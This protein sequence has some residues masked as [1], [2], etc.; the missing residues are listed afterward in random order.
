MMP[1]GTSEAKE[2]TDEVIELCNK[3]R[4][5]LEGKL[6]SACSAFE[7]KLFKQQVSFK[8]EIL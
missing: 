2:V 1:G 5:D 3:V 6:G 7:P 4:P 8:M